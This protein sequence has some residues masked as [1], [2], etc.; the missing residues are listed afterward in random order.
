EV[1]VLEDYISYLPLGTKVEVEV[2]ALPGG[3]RTFQGEVVHVVP[4]ANTLARTFPVRVRVKNEPASQVTG[5]QGLLLKA[6]M[7]ARV[8]L[9]IAPAVKQAL[10][11]PLDSIN[12]EDE[13][14]KIMIVDPESENTGKVRA[15]DVQLGVADEDFIEVI[16]VNGEL[17]PGE[18]VI[19]EGNERVR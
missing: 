12:I 15:V 9:P 1:P 2:P 7:L 5:E 11:V 18:I 6:G 10:V 19:T 17:K 16:P 4:Q 3:K 14:R 13:Q 8:R